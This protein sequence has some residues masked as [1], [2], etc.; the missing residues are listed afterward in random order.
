MVT[1]F[2]VD[3]V[4]TKIKNAIDSAIEEE[5]KPWLLDFEEHMGE[6]DVTHVAIL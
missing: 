3:A 5:Q 4:D 6:Q 2:T 1:P